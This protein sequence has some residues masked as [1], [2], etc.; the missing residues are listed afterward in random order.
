MIRK[1]KLFSRP[2]KAFDSQRIKDENAIVAKYGL[3]NK[4]EIWRA[5][6][7]L[8]IVRDAAKRVIH[9]SEEEKIRIYYKT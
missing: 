3:K 7:K 2:R 9:S 4:E 6:E 1:H 8:K 5:K